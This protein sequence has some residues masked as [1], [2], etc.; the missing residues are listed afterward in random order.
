[1]WE[2]SY[3][4]AWAKPHMRN[5]AID[6]AGLWGYRTWKARCFGR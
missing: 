1:M 6:K 2:L 5:Q 4:T 3:A